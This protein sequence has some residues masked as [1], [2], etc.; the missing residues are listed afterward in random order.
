M[1]AMG[2]FAT[3]SLYA[4]DFM[5]LEYYKCRMYTTNVYDLLVKNG[6]QSVRKNSVDSGWFESKETKTGNG[7]ANVFYI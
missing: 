1:V 6:F 2:R 5:G 3:M 4:F 7:G